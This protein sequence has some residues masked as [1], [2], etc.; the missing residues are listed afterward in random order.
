MNILKEKDY[1]QW[2]NSIKRGK[3]KELKEEEKIYKEKLKLIQEQMKQYKIIKKSNKLKSYLP[4]FLSEINDISIILTQEEQ[5]NLRNKI[6]YPNEF[7]KEN[8]IDKLTVKELLFLHNLVNDK[9]NIKNNINIITKSF[10]KLQI[11]DNI[12]TFVDLF[13]GLG[14]FHIAIKNILPESK[15]IM[16]CDNNKKVKEVY[17]KNFENINWEND[18]RTID[19]LKYGK[20]D[21]FF[22]GFVC[23]SF[24]QAG[25]RKGLLDKNF[26][27]LFFD[28]MKL[29]NI[30]QPKI[31][32]AEN[33]KGISYKR[34][35]EKVIDILF[36]YVNNETNYKM[37]YILTNPLQINIPQDR[38][39]FFFCFIRKDLYSYKQE[40]TFNKKYNELCEEYKQRN[41]FNLN[42]KNIDEKYYLKKGKENQQI[43]FSIS[44]FNELIRQLPNKKSIINLN[45]IYYNDKIKTD[46]NKILNFYQENKII[47]DNWFFKYKKFYDKQT[48][49]AL[50]ILEWSVS[51]LWNE[52][53]SIWNYI[54]HFRRSGLRIRHINYFPCLVSGDCNKIIIGKF[55]RFLTPFEC[56]KL[57]SFPEN[58]KLLEKDSESYKQFGNSVNIN[59]VEI[60]IKSLLY[61]LDKK[62]NIN[63]NIVK[64]KKIKENIF[65]IN[66]S[67]KLLTNSI[68]KLNNLF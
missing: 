39:R 62:D 3:M 53:I 15:C 5:N 31:S 29:I 44:F 24:S 38:N 28:T 46:R 14:G 37:F 18:V 41:L 67:I 22:F 34:N 60:V 16:S 33:V 49:K 11:N 4:T 13:C 55:R 45:I 23:K 64:N 58:Y 50:K 20:I 32:I 51:D 66:N 8:I 36:N 17:Y 21:C 59:I 68:N 2:I 19:I 40:Q 42:N 9:K 35:N 12:F 57:Q 30:S 63:G 1:K 26:G 48:N 61:C 7:T 10:D 43:Y 56:K 65:E 47:I 52:K 27:S 54:I 6:E 25:N